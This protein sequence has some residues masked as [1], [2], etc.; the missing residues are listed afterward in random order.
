MD[1]ITYSLRSDQPHSD[2]Y[3]WAIT[4]FT[5]EVVARVERDLG[6]HITA[7]Q[8]YLRKSEREDPR[9]R[10]E[11]GFELLMLGIFWRVY[12]QK[13][14]QLARLPRHTLTVLARWRQ[15]EG[16][17]KIAADAARGAL[18]TLFL[19][20]NGYPSPEQ[21]AL[22][23]RH[24]DRLLN[25]LAAAGDFEQEVQRLRGWQAFFVEQP[26]ED[27]R[28]QMRAITGVAD[29]F[30]ARSEVVLGQYTPHV[31][32]FL[33]ETHPHYRWREDRVFCGRQRAE[34]HLNMVGTMIMNRAF[35]T[36]F[37]ATDQKVVLVP[38]CMRIKPADQCQAQPTPFGER[39]AGCE[40]RC[41]IHQVTKL[42]EKHG[43]EVFILP[44]EL[45]S[46]APNQSTRKGLTGM[47]IV[48]VSCPL[49]NPQGGWKTRDMNLPAQGLLLDYCG[50]SWHW[51]LTGGIPT[52]INFRQLL[53]ILDMPDTGSRRTQPAQPKE[54]CTVENHPR[55]KN[56]S[57]SIAVVI[58]DDPPST[59]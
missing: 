13:A 2:E 34:Y 42:G 50:C 59:S 54:A 16:M 19:S 37:L 33:E 6:P 24:L 20:R 14:L 23:L 29:W 12:G 40:P 43:F 7:F 25:W 58:G 4:V 48:G 1:V 22:T 31:E 55:E 41:H 3:Y 44:R 28:D 8:D 56:T 15:R 53:R 26:P 35:R 46:L 11:Y 36:A 21:G 9:T 17:V 39:C 10:P 5:D 57:G 18:I 47:G 45:A 38:P 30:S 52:N 49:T 51:H 32:R 27:T